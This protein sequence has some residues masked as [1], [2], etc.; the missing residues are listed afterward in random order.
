VEAEQTAGGQWR[1]PLSE[2]ERLAREGVPEAPTFIE[3]APEVPARTPARLREDVY[4]DPSPDVIE[5]REEVSIRQSRLEARRLDK[6]IEETEDFFRERERRQSAEEAAQQEAAQ[7][8]KDRQRQAAEAARAERRRQE[9]IRRWEQYALNS[10]PYGHPQ[11]ADLAVR[12]TVQELLPTLDFDQ[13]QYITQRLVDAAVEQ[14]YRPWRLKKEA[15]DAKAEYVRTC[16]NIVSS[17]WL[18]GAT[19]SETEDAKAALAGYLADPKVFGATRTQLD[20]LK[21]AVLKDLKRKVDEREAA[22]KLEKERREK[23]VELEAKEQRKRRDAESKANSEL[24]HVQ[25]YLEAHYDF[26]G[27]YAEMLRERDRLRPLIFDTLVK[28][29]LED[30]TM[31]ADDVRGRIEELIADDEI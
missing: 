15:E 11:E 20:R 6:E 10:L 2:V 1:I 5:A 18:Y 17:I 14:T 7:A 3:E 8:A 19:S 22:A 9:Q 26:P 28:E 30:P 29:L 31:D 16:K 25:R 23:A 24:G 12:K 13:A 4:A 27:G 21:E